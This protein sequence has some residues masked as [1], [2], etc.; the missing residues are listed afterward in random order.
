MAQECDATVAEIATKARLKKILTI[1]Y[2]TNLVEK[3]F[4]TIFAVLIIH[5]QLNPIY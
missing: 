2:H 5:S 3:S 4:R 1:P